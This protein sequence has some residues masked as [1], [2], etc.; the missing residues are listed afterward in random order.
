MPLD[1]ASSKSPIFSTCEF[2]DEVLSVAMDFL[3]DAYMQ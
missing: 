2:E 1:R 3:L